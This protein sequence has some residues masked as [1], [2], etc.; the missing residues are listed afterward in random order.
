MDGLLSTMTVDTLQ[1]YGLRDMDAE[2]IQN[3]LRNQ[4]VGVLGLPTEGAPYLIPLAFGYDGEDRLYFTYFVADESRKATLSEDVDAA[5]FLVYRADSMF[6]W[7][8]VVMSGTLSEVPEAEW[9]DY[10]DALSNAWRLDIFERADT[11]GRVRIFAFEIRDR[12]GIKYAELPPG[13]RDDSN[14][15]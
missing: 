3:F 2:A 4:G 13:F 14:D 9:G 11:A 15:E 1:E 8:S 12:T 6:S 7:E 10:A 5:S